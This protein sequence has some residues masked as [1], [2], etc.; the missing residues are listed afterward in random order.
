[1]V[2]L[3]VSAYVLRLEILRGSMID[4]WIV[5]IIVLGGFFGLFTFMLAGNSVRFVFLNLTTIDQLDYKIITY[6][7]AIRVSGSINPTLANGLVSL[8]P[9]DTPV[10]SAG[11]NTFAIIQTKEGENPWDL[12]YRKNWKSIMGEH[13]IDWFLPLRSSPEIDYDSTISEYPLGPLYEALRIRHALGTIENPDEKPRP[14]R[15]HRT[16]P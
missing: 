10:P 12:G 9:P 15:K 7:L 14:G 8:P 2:C 13:P 6:W 4:P 1:M 3:G 16:R 11:I 5:L